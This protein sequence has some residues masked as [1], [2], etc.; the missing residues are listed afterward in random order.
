MY[1]DFVVLVWSFSVKIVFIDII[2]FIDWC[3]DISDINFGFYSCY[4][5]FSLDKFDL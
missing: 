2:F 5:I 4:I 3:D 1:F